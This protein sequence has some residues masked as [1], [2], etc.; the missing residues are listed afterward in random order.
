MGE[1]PRRV[2]RIELKKPEFLGDSKGPFHVHCKYSTK[3]HQFSNIFL[4]D[5]KPRIVLVTYNFRQSEVKNSY[6][7]PIL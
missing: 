4:L 3:Q 2:I 1:F 6:N 5:M 7:S